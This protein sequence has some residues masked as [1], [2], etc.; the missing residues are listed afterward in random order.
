MHIGLLII[1]QENEEQDSITSE[2]AS[3]IYK[4]QDFVPIL[5]TSQQGLTHSEEALKT[6]FLRKKLLE[7]RVMEYDIY[8]DNLSVD[9]YSQVVLANKFVEETNPENIGVFGSE[10]FVNIA[11]KIYPEYRNFIHIPTGR[12]KYTLRDKIREKILFYTLENSWKIKSN[13]IEKH[14]KALRTFHP[15]LG[16]KPKKDL[17]YLIKNT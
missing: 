8:E 1:Q 14:E 17:Y 12:E 3:Q 2:L 11:N 5:L 16:V 10:R 4:K 15:S 7:K 9:T 13:D 6:E